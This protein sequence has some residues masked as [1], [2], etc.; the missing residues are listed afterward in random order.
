VDPARFGPGVVPFPLKTTRRYRFLFVGGTIPRKGIDV[1]L[2][3]YLQTFTAEDD[4]CL[5]IKDMS[6]GSFYSEQTARER[7]AHCSARP[8]APE[9]EYIDR[10][11][12]ADELA[13]LYAACQCL[14]QPYRGE[15]FGLPIAEAMA[16]GLPVIVTGAGAALDYCTDTNAYLIPARAVRLAS[17]SIGDIATVDYPFWA[18]PDV[19]ALAHFLR[20]VVSHPAEAQVKGAAARAY[21]LDR[22]TWD[23]TADAVER[24]IDAM[25][26]GPI[27]R[28]DRSASRPVQVESPTAAP[29]SAGRVRVSLCLIVRNEEANLPDCLASAADL[30]HELIV[31]DT[32]STDG[33]REVA[34]RCGARVFD[35]PWVDDFSAARNASL[36]HATG[37]WIFWL[38]ADD[39]LDAENRR[40]LLGLFTELKDEN[41][42]YAMKCCC[43]SDPGEASVTVVDHIR[44]FRNHPEIRW[45]YRVHEQIL[46]AVRR[47]GGQVRFSDVV[48][49]HLGY[50]DAALRRRKLERDLRLLRREV[51]EQPHDPFTLFNLGSV[52]QELERPAEAL[53]LLRL[54]LERSHSSDSIVRK[55]YALIV[56]CERRLGQAAEALTTCRAGRALYP[57]DVELLF[58]ESLV[59]RALGDRAGAESCLLR[60]LET[61]EPDH[62]ASVDTGIGGFKAR[63]NL[64]VLYDEQGRLAEAAA[65]WR[66]A[67]AERPDFKP[68]WLGLAELCLRAGRWDDLESIAARLETAP[69]GGGIEAAVLKA[70]SALARREF[71]AARRLL[72]EAV[73]RAPRALAPRVL[74]S[75]A[76]LQE[77]RDPAA[78]EQALR[79]ILALDPGHA[80]ARHNLAVLLQ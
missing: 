44:L 11:L 40:K 3:A 15:A 73:A 71:P 45:R 8:G 80:E 32:G 26:A 47:Q 46:P 35:F 56:H 18:E 69:F 33:T 53:P 49:H 64:A 61:R 60:L 23:H 36:S 67:L 65:Q 1:L 66:A 13:G 75:H 19:D 17:R 22:F 74:L 63:H 6:I 7:I 79:E 38:D 9:I 12:T 57:D 68:A 51:A 37:D 29:P 31:V 55:L 5:V 20:H 4:V 30:A 72:E 25:R 24:R 59:L 14:V 77:G 50:Q 70:R 10:E 27:R 62:F 2:A 21:I 48:I 54:S 43:L 76:L 39:R 16:S 42:A 58:H 28:F 52:Y 78:A 41:V 34:T